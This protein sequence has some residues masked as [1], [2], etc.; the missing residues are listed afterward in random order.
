[1]IHKQ[2]L[3]RIVQHI[4]FAGI[5][6]ITWRQKRKEVM[7]TED[8]SAEVYNFSQHLLAELRML[9]Q[10]NCQL[11]GRSCGFGS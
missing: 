1:M 3:H 8:A 11:T 4:L 10:S 7:V 2:K 6:A 5:K 9:T